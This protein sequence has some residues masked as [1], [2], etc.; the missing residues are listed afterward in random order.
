M[1]FPAVINWTSPFLFKGLLGGIFSIFI[2]ILLEQSVST[3][4]G[5]PDQTPRYVASGL[6]L[7]CLPTSHKKDDR[8]I[9]V[10]TKI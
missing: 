2:Q 6:G 9:R 5:D 8:L 4:S 1:D 10:N 3:N 7:H